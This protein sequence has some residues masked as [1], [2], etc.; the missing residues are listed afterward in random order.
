MARRGENIH[1]RKDGR[2]EARIQIVSHNGKSTCHSVYGKTYSEVKEKKKKYLEN[3][4]QTQEFRNKKITFET[5]LDS[6]LEHRF[7]HQKDSTRLKYRNIIN[8][9]IRPKLGDIDINDIDEDFINHFLASKKE[10]GRVDKSGGLSNSYVKTMAVIINSAINYAVEKDFRVPLKAKIQKPRVDRKEVNVLSPKVQ[11]QLEDALI[12]D[13]SKTALGI[14]IAL[15]VGL[16]I[17]EICALRWEDINL[18]NRIIKVQ[19]SVVRVSNTRSDSQKTKYILAEPKTRTSIRDIPINTKLYSILVNA[20]DK[21]GYVISDTSEFICPRTFEY[22]FHKKLTEHSI[23]DINFHTLRHT[24]ATRCVENNVDTKTLS[25][26]LGHSNV[27]ITLNYYVHPS[28]DVKR[29]QLEKLCA[30]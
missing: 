30:S 17:G 6:W 13:N 25:E 8:T 1:K 24:F 7:F 3:K 19:K 5:I 28:F 23:A 27:S 16:R 10:S 9:H 20:D 22:R 15:N 2:W 18:K 11:K 14:L 21:N 12:Y 4:N 29:N 26:I